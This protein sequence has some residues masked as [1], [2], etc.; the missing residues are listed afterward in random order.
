MR[1]SLIAVCVILA[2]LVPQ[3]VALAAGGQDTDITT[4]TPSGGAGVL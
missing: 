2:G 1:R 3:S 4:V